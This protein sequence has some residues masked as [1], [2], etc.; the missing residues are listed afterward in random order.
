MLPLPAGKGVVMFSCQ[1]I[2]LAGDRGAVEFVVYGIMVVDEAG[3][4]LY[5]AAGGVLECVCTGQ[6]VTVCIFEP[7]F[8]NCAE[9]FGGKP[10]VPPRSADAVAHFPHAVRVSKPGQGSRSG[11]AELDVKIPM[12]PNTCPVAFSTMPHS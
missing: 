6:P 4:L 5:P 3:L 9:G 8:Y 7:V 11:S 1:S 2:A 10:V 12:V